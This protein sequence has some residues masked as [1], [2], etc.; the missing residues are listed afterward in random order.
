MTSIIPT[1]KHLIKVVGGELAVF[2]YGDATEKPM[3]AIHGITSN[4]L[5]WQHFAALAVA[6]GY[7]V[8]APDLRGRAAS[9]QLPAPFGMQSH[10]ADMHQVIDQLGLVNPV[11]LGHSMGGFVAIAFNHFYPG[12]ASRIVLID[13]GLPLALPAGMSVEQV[14]PLVLGP[15]LA[16]LAMTFESQAAYVDYWRAHPAFANGITPEMINYI[17]HDLIGVAPEL[18]PSTNP[19]CV[20]EDSV[21]LWSSDLIANALKA[22][23]QDVVMLRAV[24]GLQNEPT[25]LYPAQLLDDLAIKYPSVKITTIANTNHYD[26]LMSD[27]GATEIAKIISL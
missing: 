17:H 2:Q 24:R 27:Y 4:H 5:A 16:R 7:V 26:I 13:G 14:L 25:G 9:N 23:D 21:D 10:A 12:V 1:K 22:L 18:K 15:A 3:L 19:D 20:S 6:N 11:V 8:Y